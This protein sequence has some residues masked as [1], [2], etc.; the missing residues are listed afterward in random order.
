MPE[1]ARGGAFSLATTR[2]LRSAVV[3]IARRDHDREAP[4]NWPAIIDRETFER[5]QARIA[6][7]QHMAHQ[8]TGQNLLTGLIRCP[9]CGN[10]MHGNRPKHRSARYRCNSQNDGAGSPACDR[11][12]PLGVVD[13]AVLD[14]VAAVLDTVGSADAA[15]KA[16]IRRA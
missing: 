3:Y 11:C 14:E 9:T 2:H 15:L 5:V 7:H 10:R 8:A 1:D 12:L 4:G 16:A 13:S 6:E